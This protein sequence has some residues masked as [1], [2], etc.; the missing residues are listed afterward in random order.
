MAVTF[1]SKVIALLRKGAYE[2]RPVA[3]VPVARV[4]TLAIALLV[5]GVEDREVLT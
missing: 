5:L 4:L 3:R 1:D 2:T